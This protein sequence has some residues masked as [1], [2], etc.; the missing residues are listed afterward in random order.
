MNRE[1][2]ALALLFFAWLVSMGA[3]VVIEERVTA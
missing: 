2:R 3:W 1:S